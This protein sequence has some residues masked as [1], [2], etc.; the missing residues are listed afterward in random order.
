[1]ET[2]KTGATE[3]SLLTTWSSLTT[4]PGMSATRARPTTPSTRT[5]KR[6]E[7]TRQR[8]LQA[9]LAVFCE[10]GVEAATIEEV[11]DRADLGKGTFYRHFEGKES[12]LAALTADALDRLVESFRTTAR[13]PAPLHETIRRIVKAHVSFFDKHR[14]EFIL[15]F[16]GRLYLKLDRSGTEDLEKPFARYL[17]EIERETTPALPD[18]MEEDNV[19]RLV[20]ALAGFVSGYLSFAM[21]NAGLSETDTSLDTFLEGFIA[22]ALK[23]LAIDSPS[24]PV[25]H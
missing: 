15:L 7:R 8:L 24:G 11:T 16:Q 9:A 12:V 5:Q 22:G 13:E 6:V 20:I 4:L 18:S 2:E 14:S 19:R 23:H 10:K 25:G 21:I 17:E 1:M 3:H